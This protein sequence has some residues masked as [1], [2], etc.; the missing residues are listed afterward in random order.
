[1]SNSMKAKGRKTSREHNELAKLEGHTRLKP[2]GLKKGWMY[3][4]DD[5]STTVP[6]N[7]AS[8]RQAGKEEIKHQLE[9]MEYD[10]L[11]GED[12]VYNEDDELTNTFKKQ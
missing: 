12:Y 9:E 10:G 6:V 2:Y 8:A 11:T 4:R 3:T 7:K 1:M 5:R